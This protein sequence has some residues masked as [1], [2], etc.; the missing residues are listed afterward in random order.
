MYHTITFCQEKFCEILKNLVPLLFS[1]TL[2][3]SAAGNQSSRITMKRRKDC[4]CLCHRGK[5]VIF[6]VVPC[7]DGTSAWPSRARSHQRRQSNLQVKGD[8]L[9]QAVVRAGSPVML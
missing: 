9:S 2:E 1:A 3:S 8:E 4:D 7:C 5:T 6:L